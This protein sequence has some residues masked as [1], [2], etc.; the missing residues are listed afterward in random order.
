MT[1]AWGATFDPD[2]LA[3]LEL[4]M[5]KAYYA[6]RRVRLFRLLGLANREQ[7]D[8]G[9]ARA[10]AAAFWFALAASRFARATDGY[11]RFEQ[12]IVRGYRA[13]RLPAGID[14]PDV[15]RREL[16][17]WQP[18]RRARRGGSVTGGSIPMLHVGARPS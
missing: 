4:R 14:A 12:S 10:L 8:V 11:E 1:T 16:R 18:P 15:A 6:H 9:W 3:D 17:W 7:A 2:R 13:L 5:W